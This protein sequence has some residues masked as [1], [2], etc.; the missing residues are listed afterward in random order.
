MVVLLYVWHW[1]GTSGDVP[2]LLPA[3]CSQQ[4]LKPQQWDHGA[5]SKTVDI[6][7]Q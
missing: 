7:L 5:D 3:H 6:T 2:V 1:L 4:H